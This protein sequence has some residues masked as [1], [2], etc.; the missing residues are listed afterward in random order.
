M[1]LELRGYDWTMSEKFNPAGNKDA[2]ELL[3]VFF[4]FCVA[5]PFILAA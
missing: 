2:P 3:R 4:L 1:R 5:P